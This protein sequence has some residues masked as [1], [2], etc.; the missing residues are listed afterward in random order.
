MKNSLDDGFYDD[1]NLKNALNEEDIS[2]TKEINSELQDPNQ[3]DY[4][5]TQKSTADDEEYDEND[6]VSLSKMKE[7]IRLKEKNYEFE[8][9]IIR[10]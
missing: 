8:K 10:L 6:E 5:S 4:D 2:E 9:Y 1:C 3:D 7:N